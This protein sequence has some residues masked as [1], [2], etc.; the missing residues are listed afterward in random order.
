MH[1][2]KQIIKTGGSSASSTISSQKS[3]ANNLIVLEEF[4]PK[5]YFKYWFPIISRGII[6]LC[7]L[8]RSPGLNQHLKLKL[9]TCA[10]HFFNSFK[11]LL[12]QETVNV[13]RLVFSGFFNIVYFH[14]NV[15][16]ILWQNDKTTPFRKR[17]PATAH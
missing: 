14:Q 6:K 9:C 16:P 1:I 3:R 10:H 5:V 11:F 2:H 7:A 4:L 13:L 17:A 8:K 15:P 12:S